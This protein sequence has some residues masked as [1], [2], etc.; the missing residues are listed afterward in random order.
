MQLSPI[1]IFRRIY[2]KHNKLDIFLSVNIKKV[3]AHRGHNLY[4][5]YK[6]HGCTRLYPV[7]E[8]S[9]CTHVEVQCSSRGIPDTG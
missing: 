8:G 6:V 2:T 7:N 1:R 3:T 4:K 5:S 9:Q